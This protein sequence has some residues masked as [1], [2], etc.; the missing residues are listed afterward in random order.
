VVQY[1]YN[2]VDCELETTPLQ[3]FR[4]EVRI[5]RLIEYLPSGCWKWTG[6]MPAGSDSPILPLSIGRVIYV[7]RWIYEKLRSRIPDKLFLS[8]ICPT[9]GCVN[10]FH[11]LPLSRPLVKKRNPNIG[12]KLTPES[13]KSLLH[14]V[15]VRG[16]PV[17]LAG[18]KYGCTQE[19]VTQIINRFKGKAGVKLIRDGVVPEGVRESILR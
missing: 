4:N 6:L 16:M 9:K 19:N 5:G 7:R 1:T 17:T 14:D 13:R 15:I 12:Q 3:A 10:P 8:T 11:C 18:I 2:M